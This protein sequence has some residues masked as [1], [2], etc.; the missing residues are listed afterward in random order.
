MDRLRERPK[1]A[2]VQL[3]SAVVLVVL[4]AAVPLS[5]STGAALFGA[6]PLAFC[7]AALMATMTAVPFFLFIWW[8]DRNEPEP[9]YMLALAF[10]WGAFVAT[11]VSM[12]VNGAMGLVFGA[13]ASPE[14][15]AQLTAS[16]SAPF[17]EELTKGCAL[18]LIYAMFRREF[19]NMLDGI[20]YG[21][22]VGLGF[23]WYENITYY[24]APFLDSDPKTGL[25]DM[26]LTA[27]MRGIVSASGGSHA[28]YTAL[29]GAAVG[30]YREK[31]GASI[32]L[33][34]LGMGLA[35]FSHAAWNTFAGGIM[36]LF[37]GGSETM[38]IVA[39]L[40]AAVL[41]LQLPFA[42]ML[43]LGVVFGWHRERKIIGSHLALE[44]RE[45]VR[46]EELASFQ[47]GFG[48]RLHSYWLYL[49]GSRRKKLRNRLARAQVRLAFSRWHHGKDSRIDWSPEEDK[50][51]TLRRERVLALR[52]EL[53]TLA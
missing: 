33:L 39:G 51:I 8:L 48:N 36:E 31:G 13:V 47:G 34:P 50:E 45:M 41:V 2:A 25:G 20:V 5:R 4:L 7:L 52:R 12:V 35:M 46:E 18:L 16:L 1:T 26:M 19:D 32:L 44:S 24:M 38:G 21:A 3:L 49:F 30:L 37:S 15:A 11:A 10:L 42:G 23:A 40:P 22:V 29:T 17:I 27:Y 53:E 43:L 14:A 6:H 9:L 28:A